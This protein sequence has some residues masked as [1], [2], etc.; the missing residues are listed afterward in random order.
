[1]KRKRND[2]PEKS[3][4]RTYEKQQAIDRQALLLIPALGIE[5]AYRAV[6]PGPPV[7]VRAKSNE[8]PLFRDL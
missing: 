4:L 1:M 8:L 2:M 7:L 5:G 6:C 3:V